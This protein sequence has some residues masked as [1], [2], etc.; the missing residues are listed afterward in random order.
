M[1]VVQVSALLQE[2]KGVSDLDGDQ[3]RDQRKDRLEGVGHACGDATRAFK[4]V[5]CATSTFT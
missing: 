3:W 1:P 4:V 5:T 2:G